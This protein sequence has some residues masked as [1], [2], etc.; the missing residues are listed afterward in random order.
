VG[1]GG[2][3]FVVAGPENSSVAN[4]LNQ[5]LLEITNDLTLSAGAHRITLGTHNEFFEFSNLFAQ[6][7]YG[8][9]R[10]ADTTALKAG[11]PNQYSFTYRNPN[12]NERA[13]FKVRQLSGYIQD[14]W[15]ARDNLTVTAGLRLDA[16]RFPD[17]PALNDTVQKYYQRSTSSV[18]GE[19]IQFSPRLGFNWD[20]TGDQATQL[21]GGVGLFSGRTPYVWVSNAYGNTGLDYTASP[22]P[23]RR[24]RRTPRRASSPTRPASRA[25]ARAPPATPRTRSTRCRRTSSC[26]RCSAPRWASTA[27]CRVTSW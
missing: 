8:N 21:R 20:V 12:G 2:T 16:T 22:A 9:Y 24:R 11:T 26:R 5:D 13:E 1:A 23:T 17:K 25:P 6:N 19:D 3:N 4:A 7:I 15:E 18:G 14:Q 27:G 10:F